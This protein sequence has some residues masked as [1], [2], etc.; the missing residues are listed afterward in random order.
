MKKR[1]KQL[2]ALA[3]AVVTLGMSSFTALADEDPYPLKG[4]I[5]Y[6]LITRE[7]IDAKIADGWVFGGDP[8]ATVGK[9]E[10]FANNAEWA[11]S[12]SFHDS[13]FTDIKYGKILLNLAGLTPIPDMY[14]GS[15]DLTEKELALKNEVVK[16]LNSY[17]WKNAS[18][19]EKAAY[20]AHYIAERATYNSDVYIRMVNGETIDPSEE[21]NSA[22]S[23]LVQ[24]HSL[25]DGFAQA[26]H[27]LTRAVGLKCVEGSSYLHGWNYVMI[28]GKWHEIDVSAASQEMKHYP[29]TVER[30]LGN[31]AT[32]L[33][34]N[35]WTLAGIELDFDPTLP[36]EPI[37]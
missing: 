20:T 17:D 30:Q 28:D 5:G 10:L 23:A 1:M 36:S 9:A 12:N 34:E 19:Y 16:Y 29:D 11:Q 21:E 37:Y 27:L 15:S 6:T 18:E 32:R 2:A 7:S 4:R 22:Y 35:I 24:G 31:Q 3:M 13:Q 26:Y 14:S 25:C 33:E 8:Y